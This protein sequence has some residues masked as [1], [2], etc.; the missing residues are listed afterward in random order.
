MSFSY[1][2]WLFS[3]LLTLWSSQFEFSLQTL[4][5]RLPLGWSSAL[6]PHDSVQRLSYL[7]VSRSFS[8]NRYSQSA[9]PSCSRVGRGIGSAFALQWPMQGV[10]V[11][12]A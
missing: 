3:I 6:F 7:L 5:R 9:F 1:R 12:K 2:R 4:L 10:R 11:G 8:S